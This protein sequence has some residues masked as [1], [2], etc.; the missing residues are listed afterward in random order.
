MTK[1]SSFYENPR[2]YDIAFSYRNFSEEIEVIRLWY[3][4]FS[5][6]K[7]LSSLLELAA[8][9]ARHSLEFANSGIRATAIDISP[10][11][12]RYAKLL[13]R[14]ANVVLDVMQ[15]DMINFSINKK[16][17]LAVQMLDSASH[18]LSESQMIAHLLCV[19]QHLRPGGIYVVEMARAI[20]NRQS[21][22]TKSE[23]EVNRQGT[24]VRVQWAAAEDTKI[25]KPVG[26]PTKII[27][28]VETR[29]GKNHFEDEILQKQWRKYQIEKCINFTEIFEIVASYGAFDETISPNDKSAWRLILILRKLS[30]AN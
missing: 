21:S 2:I 24:K 28:D 12:C 3:H 18:I 16:F 14:R 25:R 7:K 30:S 23:W 1:S 11:M 10:A 22:T 19:G 15:A 9:P 27:V 20:T 5:K 6:K 26:T 13:A 4:K 29:T 17:D 8:G